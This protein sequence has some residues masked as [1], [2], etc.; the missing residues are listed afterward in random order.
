MTGERGM[1]ISRSTFAGSGRL[2]GATLGNNFAT[3]DDLKHSIIGML[4]H[5]LFGIP[6]VRLQGHLKSKHNQLK[7]QQLKITQ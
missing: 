7:I 2:A 4:E 3:W 6:Y 5:N 1:V